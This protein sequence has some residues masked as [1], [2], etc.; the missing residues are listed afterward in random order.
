MKLFICKNIFACLFSVHNTIGLSRH[1]Q[2]VLMRL[3]FKR[4]FSHHLATLM[5]MSPIF[6]GNMWTWTETIKLTDKKKLTKVINK[7]NWTVKLYE[8]KN[9]E[10][11]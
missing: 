5:I 3:G 9:D 1:E 6:K 4:Y 7:N 2:V 11:A 10:F 8:C